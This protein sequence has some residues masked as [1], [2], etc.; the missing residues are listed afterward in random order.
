MLGESGDPERAVVALL[1][2]TA[3]TI[4]I[5]APNLGPGE[6]RVGSCADDMQVPSTF[7]TRLLSSL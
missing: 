1:I 4:S 6:D 2:H 7:S 3:G 5:S